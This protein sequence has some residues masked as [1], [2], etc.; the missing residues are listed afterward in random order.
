MKIN[1]RSYISGSALVFALF[2][3]ALPS[4]GM[5]KDPPSTS[6]NLNRRNSM[7]RLLDLPAEMTEVTYDFK[8]EDLAREH[9]T[10]YLRLCRLS[11]NFGFY[12][13]KNRLVIDISFPELK[14]LA[15]KTLAKEVYETHVGPIENITIHRGDDFSKK[16]EKKEKLYELFIDVAI[17]IDEADKSR[18]KE[19]FWALV[20]N[21]SGQQRV[22]SLIVLEALRKAKSN[23]LSAPFLENGKKLS[24]MFGKENCYMP[25]SNTIELCE[26]PMEKVLL[27]YNET[28][29]QVEFE[30]NVKLASSLMHESGHM[31]HKALGIPTDGVE[32]AALMGIL[33][34][35]RFREGLIPLLS[36]DIF[37]EVCKSIENSAEAKTELLKNEW[38]F[39][40]SHADYTINKEEKEFRILLKKNKY[41]G[42][43]MED[44]ESNLAKKA[45]LRMI[46][47]FAVIDPE[48]TLTINGILPLSFVDPNSKTSKKFAIID[49]ENEDTMLIRAKGLTRYL[50]RGIESIAMIFGEWTGNFMDSL[51]NAMKQHKNSLYLSKIEMISSP[52]VSLYYTPIKE[53]PIVTPQMSAGCIDACLRDLYGIKDRKLLLGDDIK[54]ALTKDN[55][56]GMNTITALIDVMLRPNENHYLGR[57]VIDFALDEIEKAAKKLGLCPKL[58]K[59]VSTIEFDR[60]DAREAVKAFFKFDNL[61]KYLAAEDPKIGWLANY[62][63]S[64]EH[65]N[66]PVPRISEYIELRKRGNEEVEPEG[67]KEA[68]EAGLE[69]MK[70]KD[71]SLYNCIVAPFEEQLKSN[72]FANTI[73]GVMLGK[74]ELPN[75]LEAAKKAEKL[76][77]EKISKRKRVVERRLWD[78]FGVENLENLLLVKRVSTLDCVD[79]WISTVDSSKATGKI[80]NL[81]K[82]AAWLSYAE[83]SPLEK[84]WNLVAQQTR[85]GQ[86]VTEKDIQTKMAESLEQLRLRIEGLCK[87]RECEKAPGKFQENDYVKYIEPLINWLLSA[88]FSKI[89]ITIVLDETGIQTE[90]KKLEEEEQK[91]AMKEELTRK[92][93]ME[94]R[95]WSD[96]KL[97]SFFEPQNLREC[98]TEQKELIDRIPI[99]ILH[100]QNDQN[101]TV[102]KIK[103]YVA[104]WNVEDIEIIKTAIV[105]G[106]IVETNPNV[107]MP[108]KVY[109]H[110]LKNIIEKGLDELKEEVSQRAYQI[111]EAQRKELTSDAFLNAIVCAALSGLVN[112]KAVK[113]SIQIELKNREIEEK[114]R[115]AML[116]KKAD[117]RSK[118]QAFLTWQNLEQCLENKLRPKRTLND[119]S[120]FLVGDSSSNWLLSRIYRHMEDTLWGTEG[121]VTKDD[122]KKLMT[123][124]LNQMVGE[125]LYLDYGPLRSQ[126]MSDAFAQALEDTMNGKLVNLAKLKGDISMEV[127]DK[128][129]EERN[130]VEKA[131][132][133]LRD[134]F[135]RDSLV[136]C[137]NKPSD[138]WKLNY[139]SLY[140]RYESI[141]FPLTL[142]SNYVGKQNYLK[143]PVKV[144]ELREAMN[145]GLNELKDEKKYNCYV[146][147]I[148]SM[149]T[150]LQSTAFLN[151]IVSVV[152]S[153]GINPETLKADIAKELGSPIKV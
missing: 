96:K 151:A 4:H 71:L 28:E 70:G 59:T 26:G 12:D 58:N 91:Q 61:E 147:C 94:H 32:K 80:V 20:D 21:A 113:V 6:N 106:A 30:K 84:I 78:F 125:V 41:F 98:F 149:R 115:K 93:E 150:Q 143:K 27:G 55:S 129:P 135:G 116:V 43:N 31:C 117:A 25:G 114:N 5:F 97:D 73:V 130:E 48:E 54:Y 126:L 82:T 47:Y 17:D 68:L 34:D 53:N 36:K 134:F 65:G 3:L 7:P 46:Y 83:N 118:L 99:C 136:Q 77:L 109:R 102:D 132:D 56:N 33:E 137:L 72:E 40:E 35:E 139:I 13:A 81:D 79:R 153:V 29:N 138:S 85:K 108:L 145:Q 64:T 152:T 14:K 89:I 10:N 39:N 67:I 131:K 75:R 49:R 90:I 110:K 37:D 88:G 11:E 100:N 18:F 38:F 76:E 140:I 128:T 24:V 95:A 23:V 52:S 120:L 16:E 112:P 104:T 19:I 15:K 2:G 119:M 57:P 133:A 50:H 122:L 103:S 101:S 63:S 141:S 62:L 51:T 92:G 9:N 66:F 45:L 107:K 87:E 42:L 60:M 123:E 124:F 148:D 74:M 1:N 105:G 69:G 8:K 86:P 121:T 146:E 144:D 111:P 22:K 142:I 127:E 44:L